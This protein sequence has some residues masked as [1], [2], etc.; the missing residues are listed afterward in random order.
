MGFFGGDGML[1]M[2]ESSLCLIVLDFIYGVDF[3][4]KEFFEI[5][6]EFN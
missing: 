1:C 4:I 5:G 6:I 3:L 2:I